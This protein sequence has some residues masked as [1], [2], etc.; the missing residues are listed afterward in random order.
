MK[1]TKTLTPLLAGALLMAMIGTAGAAGTAAAEQAAQPATDTSQPAMADHAA[2]PA[3]PATEKAAKPEHVARA[4]TAQECSAYMA[5]QAQPGARND[6]TAKQDEAYC[7][8][9]LEKNLAK[10]GKL[11]T[12]NVTQSN[13]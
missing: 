10:Q 2:K 13:G 9:K 3:A 1:S 11:P 6:A 5:R 7:A 4:M 12:S 8:R